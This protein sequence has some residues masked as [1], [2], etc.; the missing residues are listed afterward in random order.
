MRGACAKGYR[1]R[2]KIF[3]YIV[4][5]SSA[6]EDLSFEDSAMIL[7]ILWARYLFPPVFLEIVPRIETSYPNVSVK[8]NHTAIVLICSTSL[9]SIDLAI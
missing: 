2:S 6:A 4:A 1:R 7:E 9:F 3:V 5:V 8:L